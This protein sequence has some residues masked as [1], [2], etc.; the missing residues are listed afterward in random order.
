MVD[1]LGFQSPHVDMSD[2]ILQ[3]LSAGAVVSTEVPYSAMSPSFL[4]ASNHRY[5]WLR[6]MATSEI[7]TRRLR[8]TRSVATDQQ[9]GSPP[10]HLATAAWSLRPLR[11]AH[12]RSTGAEIE[13]PEEWSGT[14]PPKLRRSLQYL[15]A[16]ATSR[17]GRSGSTRSPRPSCAGRPWRC[18]PA[19]AR[20]GPCRLRQA[21]AER[22]HRTHRERRSNSPPV[23]AWT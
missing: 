23:A 9:S 13:F 6:R 10:S 11:A 7:D 20:S 8:Q 3:T 22:E 18:A 21:R 14:R 12:R 5:L 17:L 19:R 4:L 2:Q 15:L 1:T 16:R